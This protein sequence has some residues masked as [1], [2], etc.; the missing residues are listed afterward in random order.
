M[1]KKQDVISFFAYICIALIPVVVFMGCLGN[2]KRAQEQNEQTNIEFNDFNS[3]G[4]DADIEKVI[5]VYI[6]KTGRCYHTEDC[7]YA[8]NASEMLTFEQAESRGYRP[9]SFCC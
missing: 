3:T 9:C 1:I 5:T 7:A 2:L 6:T 8:K 4:F